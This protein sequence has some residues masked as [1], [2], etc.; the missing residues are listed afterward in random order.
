MWCSTKQLSATFTQPGGSHVSYE[1][2]LTTTVIPIM[3]LAFTVAAAVI[4]NLVVKRWREGGRIH[5][6]LGCMLV[7]LGMHWVFLAVHTLHLVAFAG[8]V[9]FCQGNLCHRV[10]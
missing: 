9:L 5:P 4:A 8:D 10:R 2:K 7:A 3:L 6:T 1:D